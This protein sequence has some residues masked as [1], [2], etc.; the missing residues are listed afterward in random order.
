M[1]RG[2]RRTALEAFLASVVQATL[3][4]LAYDEHSAEWHAIERARLERLG[5]VAPFVD[6]QIA[7]IA[8]TNGLTLVT[9]NTADFKLFKNLT[10]VN[11][12]E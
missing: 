5:K 3:P 4:V 10:I 2:G 12:L 9:A 11:W 1:S 7:A 6:G 8:A